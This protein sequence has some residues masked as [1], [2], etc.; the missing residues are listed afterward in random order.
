MLALKSLGFAALLGDV[1]WR[2][3][4]LAWLVTPPP[5]LTL[6]SAIIAAPVLAGSE[7]ASAA[8]TCVLSAVTAAVRGSG[9]IAIFHP[10]R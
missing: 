3:V 9:V 2:R 7:A 8:V 4:W 5:L 1:A 10:S 6:A